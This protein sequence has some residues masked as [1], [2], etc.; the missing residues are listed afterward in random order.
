MIV[1]EVAHHATEHASWWRESLNIVR[2]P[3]HWIGEFSIEFFFAVFGVHALHK[4]AHTTARRVLR[5]ML[6]VRRAFTTG[7]LR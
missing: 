3:A 1:S 7:G 5:S 6:K 2:N 4:V